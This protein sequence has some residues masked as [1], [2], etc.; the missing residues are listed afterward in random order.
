[1]VCLDTGNAFRLYDIAR[2]ARIY[3]TDSPRIL[4][5][6]FISRAFTAYQLVALVMDKIE[7]AVPKFGA[8]R[9]TISDIL[10]LF[11]SDDLEDHEAQE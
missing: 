4:G 10:G 8:K 5:N 7:D 9:V 2:L 6:I 3:Q 11:L 1:V